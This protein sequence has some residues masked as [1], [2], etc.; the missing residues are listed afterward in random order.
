[1]SQPIGRLPT[2][3]LRTQAPAQAVVENTIPVEP[4]TSKIC[5][6]CKTPTKLRCSS[7]RAIHY[8]SGNCQKLAWKTHKKVCKELGVNYKHSKKMLEVAARGGVE[9][10]AQTLLI[11]PEL[12]LHV[13][14]SKGRNILHLFALNFLRNAVMIHMCKEDQESLTLRMIDFF[15]IIIKSAY[16]LKNQ[17]DKAGLTPGDYFSEQLAEFSKKEPELIGND[18]YNFLTNVFSKNIKFENI[19][20][21]GK[22]SLKLS[23][24]SSC[25]SGYE[26][27]Y[28]IPFSVEVANEGHE[29]DEKC[30]FTEGKRHSAKMPDQLKSLDAIRSRKTLK[31]AKEANLFKLLNVFQHFP[32][33]NLQIIDKTGSNVLHYLA[34]H[35][36]NKR[37]VKIGKKEGGKF[38]AESFALIMYYLG[39]SSLVLKKQKNAGG[40]TPVEIHKKNIERLNFLSNRDSAFTRTAL[41]INSLLCPNS[42]LTFF[43]PARGINAL[44][45][46]NPDRELYQEVLD[47]PIFIHNIGACDSCDDRTIFSREL[48]IE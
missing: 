8:C 12:D 30:V 20:H 47:S 42:T 14:D 36:F 27:I 28:L 45:I 46:E 9:K 38:I 16:I 23:H 29:C 35:M 26:A 2:S 22:R 7:C 25:D 19:E 11:F 17:K 6:W 40:E 24:D 43:Q 31:V 32:N 15:N 34:N 39:K 13:Q 4:L 41:I 21:Q 33:I 18:F 1:M 10:I 37:N 3:G 48:A 44:I 5:S